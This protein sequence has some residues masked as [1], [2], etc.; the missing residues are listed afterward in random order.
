[1]T[2][3]ELKQLRNRLNDLSD[4]K[5]SA[6]LSTVFGA[7]SFYAENKDRTAI[8]LIQTIERSVSDFEEFERSEN[9]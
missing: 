6:I 2:K 5:Q 8:D 4:V 9:E 3:E 1:M 7:L